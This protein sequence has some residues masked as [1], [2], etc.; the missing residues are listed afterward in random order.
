MK[1]FSG[2]L[3]IALALMLAVSCTQYVYVPFP[4]VDNDNEEPSV[5]QKTESGTSVISQIANANDGDVI[6]LADNT[7]Y[8]FNQVLDLDKAITLRGGD[9]TVLDFSNGMN[10]QP[11]SF[12]ED[13]P[14]GVFYGLVNI[15]SDGVTLENLKIVGDLSLSRN[16]PITDTSK[17]AAR[18]YGLFISRTAN[19]SY[20]EVQDTITLR[21]I[22]ISET[23]MGGLYAY[24]I[25]ADESMGDKN[26]LEIYNLYV[27]D[28]GDIQNTGV[29]APGIL[30]Q[31]G[32]NILVDGADI[33]SGNSGPAVYIH[34][35]EVH[36]PIVFQ[37]TKNL[38]GRYLDQ[39]TEYGFAFA[40][41]DTK[42]GAFSNM[43]NPLMIHLN[44]DDAQSS[45]QSRYDEF[46][47]GTF[48]D[49]VSLKNM[50]A[51]NPYYL[52][53][54]WYGIDTIT[55]GSDYQITADNYAARKVQWG[56]PVFC[57]D[58]TNR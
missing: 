48:T 45:T 43:D 12:E 25:Y 57:I 27:H 51:D 50:Q 22:E 13:N 1:R 18:A 34:M 17:N 31:S 37:N 6:T 55:D 47:N 39:Y 5:V 9:N 30:F 7:T 42:A 11:Y 36:G 38:S 40:S 41:D 8:E 35:S 58:N 54:D 20:T 15:Y 21:N 46:L 14:N 28:I 32:K 53:L 10:G 19:G 26:A 16:T 52:K 29:F 23:T 44:I 24:R 2:V 33:D 49:S 3:I 4:V 56:S